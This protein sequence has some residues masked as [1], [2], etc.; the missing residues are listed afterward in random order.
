MRGMFAS[1]GHQA[2]WLSCNPMKSDSPLEK[3]RPASHTGRGAASLIPHLHHRTPLEPGE[4]DEVEP[5]D[6]VCE[7]KQSKSDAPPNNPPA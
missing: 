1:D 5:G 3:N 4:L 6:P 7:D 2:A